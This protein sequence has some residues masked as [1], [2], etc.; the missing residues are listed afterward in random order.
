[1]NKFRIRGAFIFF[2]TI[3]Q[4]FALPVHGQSSGGD[5]EKSFSL[6]IGFVSTTMVGQ[7]FPGMMGHYILFY[8]DRLGTGLSLFTVQS[9]INQNFGFSVLNPQLMMGQYGWLNQFILI[10]NKYVKFKINFT[11]GLMQ[12]SLLD[13]GQPANTGTTVASTNLDRNYYYFLEPGAALSLRLFGPLYLTGGINYRY[14]YGKSNFSN[15]KEFQNSD[16]S[17]GLSM[18]NNRK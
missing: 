6:E 7:V 15:R 5:N 2:L 12:V 4:T 1:M 18:I 9:Q 3:C 11:N 16:Y 17:L 8:T 10:N 13:E 14:L